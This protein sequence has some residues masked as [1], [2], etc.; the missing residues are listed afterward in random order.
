MNWLVVGG[1]GALG[2]LCR[3]AIDL[4]LTGQWTWPWPTLSINILGSFVAGAL[5]A[6]LQSKGSSAS[7]LQR[8]ILIGFCGGFTT[9]SAFSVQTLELLQNQRWSAAALYLVVSPIACVF[10]AGMGYRIWINS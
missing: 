4:R 7:D 1:L 6:W 5:L 9:F 3:Y 8:W 10:A 2:V